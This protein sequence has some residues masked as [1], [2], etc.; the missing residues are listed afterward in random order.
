VLV[1]GAGGMLGHKVFQAAA[2]K[3]SDTWASIQGRI[4]DYPVE[5]IAAF[6]SSQV[7]EQI[8]AMNLGSVGHLLDRVKPTVVINCIGVIK[9]RPA[10]HD[11]VASVAINALL[12]HWL[13]SRLEEWGGRLIHISTDC[14]F[15]G[16]R[17]YYT[18]NDL[19]DAVDLY[20]RTKALGEVD[21]SNA[22][23]L[24]TSIIG[25]ELRTHKSL[26]DWFLSQNHGTVSGYQRAWWSGVTT[27]HLSDLIVSLIIDH[28]SLSGLFQV[29]SGRLSKYDLLVML[30]D[31][32]DLDI[33]V[34]PDQSYVLDRSLTGDKL[35][36]AIG[37]QSPPWSQLLSQ[38][39]SDFTPY[40]MPHTVSS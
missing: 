18:E 24:R 35:K 6:G 40:P 4:R 13:S 34:R 2:S 16:K 11:S 29:S 21:S 9:Q 22:I 10:A 39:V 5:G 30:R 33:T 26:L 25:R 20:G 32:Y 1:L 17:G 37:Y 14:V 8:D 28:P 38:L 31:A 36:A 12:P 3:F 27:N 7:V 19:P 23:T 15:D